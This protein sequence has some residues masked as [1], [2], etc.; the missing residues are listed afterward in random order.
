[1]HPLKLTFILRVNNV[2]AI[3]SI[4]EDRAV[5]GGPHHHNRGAIK[6]YIKST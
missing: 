1:M 5:E 3:S 4:L 2:E 6:E